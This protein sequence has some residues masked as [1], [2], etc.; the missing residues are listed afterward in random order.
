MKKQISIEEP[1]LFIPH[2][3]LLDASHHKNLTMTRA[4]KFSTFYLQR[5]SMTTVENS[6]HILTQEFLHSR[7]SSC[8]V[9]RSLIIRS[10][11][12]LHRGPEMRGHWLG[13]DRLV[14]RFLDHDSCG[15]RIFYREFHHFCRGWK[16]VIVG[17][18]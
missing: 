17:D 5:T 15:A 8:T 3:L 18:T 7:L 10:L 11:V 16:N 13:R 6:R 12:L 14:S 9:R 1:Q 2:R 4:S